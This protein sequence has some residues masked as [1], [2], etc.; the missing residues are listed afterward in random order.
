MS[1]ELRGLFTPVGYED[2]LKQTVEDLGVP[3]MSITYLDADQTR[4]YAP[5]I[6]GS[7]SAM[8]LINVPPWQFDDICDQVFVS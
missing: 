7:K 8:L 3:V 5:E 1:K 6:E 2:Q 4:K